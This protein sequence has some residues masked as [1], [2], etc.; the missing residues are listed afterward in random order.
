M[1]LGGRPVA[2]FF[3][4]TVPMLLPALVSG[5]LLAFAL[6]LDDL[7]ISSFV[8]GPGAT[9]LPMLIFAKVRLG[10]TPDI[11][12]ITTIIIALVAVAVATAAALF[13]ARRRPRRGMKDMKHEPW[14]ACCMPADGFALPGAL[15]RDPDIYEQEIRA[16]FLKSWLYVGHQSQIPRARRL[17]PVRDRGRVRHR[18]AGR[19]RADQ[20][21]AE[22]VPPPRLAHLRRGRRAR[23]TAHLPLSRLDVWAGWLAARGEPHAGRLRPFAPTACVALHVQRV[24]GADLHQFRSAPGA[25]RSASRTIWPRRSRRIGSSTRKSLIRQNYPITSN[26]KLAVENYCECYHCAPAHPEYSVGHGRA[27]PPPDR[28]SCSRR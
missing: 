24:R 15:Y 13:T 8:S 14:I 22:R 1:D 3:D 18:R 27:I 6:S 21:A 25:V 10:V 7:V 12:A 26:W 23:G 17:F 16:I 9:T 20:R 11:N 28:R 2:V 19:G 4:I 5:W